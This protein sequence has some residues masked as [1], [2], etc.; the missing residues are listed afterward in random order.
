MYTVYFLFSCIIS[1]LQLTLYIDGAVLIQC[2]PNLMV[3]RN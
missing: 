3:K 1:T 2:L